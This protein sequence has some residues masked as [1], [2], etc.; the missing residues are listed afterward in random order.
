MPREQV[1]ARADSDTVRA[2]EEYAEERDIT[3]SE[4]IRRL[5]RQSLAQEGYGV[6]AADGG[7]VDAVENLEERI[8]EIEE[9]RRRYEKTQTRIGALA[10]GYIGILVLAFGAGPLVKAVVA[11]GGVSL[12]VILVVM[13]RVVW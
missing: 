6:A 1:Q 8:D 11:I 5:L 2:M 13:T 4:A 10:V 9:S 12:A 3:R 7:M